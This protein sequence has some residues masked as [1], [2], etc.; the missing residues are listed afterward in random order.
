MKN[1][2]STLKS[3]EVNDFWKVAELAA[4]DMEKHQTN[5]IEAIEAAVREVREQRNIQN[6][7]GLKN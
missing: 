6:Q 5:N 7:A 1:K 2:Q 4:A 3:S